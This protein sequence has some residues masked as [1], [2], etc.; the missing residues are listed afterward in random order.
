MD[1]RHYL[2]G[3]AGH[4]DH[5]KTELIRALS[6]IE[7]DRLKEEKQRGIS[8]E[9]G[10]AHMMLPSGR[11]VGIVDVPGHERFVRQ[12]LAG[13]SGMDVVLLVIAAD[14]GIMPQTQEHLDILTLLDIPRGIV[15]INKVDLVDE[16]WLDLMEEEIREDLKETAFREAPICRVS[17]LSGVGIPALRQTIDGLLSEVESKKSTGPVRMP[18]DRIFSIQGFGTVVTGT[19]HSGTV[20]LG[21]ELVIEPGHIHAKV[22]SL[23]VH[24]NKMNSAGAG[25]RLAVNIAGVDVA[26][27]GRGSVLVMPDAFK[28]GKILDLKVQN[29]S[30]ADKP[31]TQ[32]QR[33][34]FHL[35]TTEVLGRIHLLEQEELAPGQE[36]F[37]QILLEGPVVAAPEDRFVLRFYSPAHTIAGGK[38]LGVA[39]FKQKRFKESVLAQ[40]R[41]KDQGDPLDLLER[42]IAEPRLGSDLVARLHVS[43]VELE[44]R[45]KSLEEFERLEVWRED[46]NPLYWGKAAAEAWRSKLINLVKIYEGLNPLRGGISR[47]E[48]K[49]RL[50]IS[51]THRRW[52]TILEQGFSRGFYRIVGS[53]VQT[54]AGAEI[55]PSILKRLDALRS[56]WQSVALMPPDLVTTAEACGIPKSEAQEYAQYLCEIGEWVH[57]D[58]FYYRQKDLELAKVSLIE[59][60]IA[61]GDIGVSDVREIWSTSRK[62][63]VPL[64][65]FWDDQ[66]IT[67]RIGDK[68]IL[69]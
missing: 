7:T 60:L 40:M 6:G 27:I 45:L 50:G 21:Q 33:V 41:V 26:E 10:F 30:S 9:L 15:V 51:W 59:F 14:E 48:L 66:K 39:E 11:Q 20:K 5:G 69:Y 46:E 4:V 44:D 18:L 17:A 25:Q 61:Q 1:E 42:E 23:Q 47:E 54:N 29:L 13:A 3:T 34:R 49:T 56:K 68:R 16:E 58:Q 12:M 55:P 57:I 62:Y 64:L 67:K 31:L 19:L 24:K 22:R 43:S 63:A 2:I 28:V 37:A 36:G 65:E 32:R 8:I 38:V 53:K 35:G 52:Q